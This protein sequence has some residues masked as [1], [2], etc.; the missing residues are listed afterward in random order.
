MPLTP[1]ISIPPTPRVYAFLVFS[2]VLY[3]G[4]NILTISGTTQ[5]YPTNLHISPGWAFSA[6]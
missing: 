2:V 6:L 3:P 5:R 4:F 1:Y